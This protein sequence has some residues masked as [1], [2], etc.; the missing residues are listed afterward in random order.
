MKTMFKYATAAAL[1]GTLALAA[2]APAQAENGRNAAA[3]IGSASD[4]AA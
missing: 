2:M 1:A 4:E 3:A